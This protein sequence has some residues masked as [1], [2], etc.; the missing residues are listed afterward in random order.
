MKPDK[1]TI[2]DILFEERNKEYGSYRL[3]KFYHARL[4]I[5]FTI[6]L[7]VL[8]L[9]TFCYYWYVN[10]GGDA[11][12]YFYLNARQQLKSVDGSM[13]SSRELAAY[14]HA[15]KPDAPPPDVVAPT[16]VE[17]MKNFTVTKDATPDSFKKPVEDEPAQE[18]QS[19]AGMV[20]DSTVF[21]GY[22]LGN[23]QGI[24][25]K[26]DHIPIFPEGNVT[27]YVERTLKYPSQ[28]MKKKISGVVVVS[29]IINKTGKVVNVKVERGVDPII[30][31]EA[32]KTIKNMPQWKPATR[33]GKPINFMFMMP[34]N[35]IPLS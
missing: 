23:G 3:R 25:D 28:A 10:T 15:V 16:D 33:H 2:D 7:S 8:L 4:A 35:F 13:M 27:Q 5:S 19:T 30:D 11:E 1:K 32:I 14:A 34:I 17:G 31:A 21:G 18:D 24:S 12:T 20:D 26:V 22:L 29:F 9:L 6:A